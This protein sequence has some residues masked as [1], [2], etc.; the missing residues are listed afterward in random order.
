M[1]RLTMIQVY[2]SQPHWVWV[3]GISSGA[4][5]LLCLEAYVAAT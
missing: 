5:Q 1:R 3:M 4:F 2:R